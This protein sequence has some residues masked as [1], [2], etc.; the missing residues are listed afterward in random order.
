VR[1]GGRVLLFGGC[2]PATTVSFDAA[3]LHYSE[4]S[5]IGSFHSTPA[6]AAEAL[7]LLASGDVDPL[8][9]ISGTGG[10]GDVAR[11]FVALWAGEAI[12]FAVRPRG[13]AEPSLP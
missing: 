8:P 6:E 7:A 10:L 3:R 11:F 2:A 4:I 9:L 12:R 13:D 1:P 5:L